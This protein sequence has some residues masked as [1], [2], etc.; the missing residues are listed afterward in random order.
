MSGDKGKVPPKKT[1]PKKTPVV[2]APPVKT[3]VAKAAAAKA[4]AAKTP[5]GHSSGKKVAAKSKDPRFAER[6]HTAY[7]RSLSSIIWLQ[8]QLNDPYV[9]RAKEE[10]W[11]SRAAFKL[12]E[13]DEKH[14][15]LK[16]GQTIIDLGCA[17][18]GWCQYAAKKVGSASGKSGQGKAGIVIGIDLLPVEPIVGVTLAEMDF[19]EEDA[20]DRLRAMLGVESGQR[21]VDGV[22][23]DMAANTTGHRKTDHLRI[24]G[25]TEMA[26]EFAIEMLKPGGFFITKLFQGGET[27]AMIT[28]LK[29]HFSVVKHVKPQSSRADSAEL[30]VLA[31]G[32]KG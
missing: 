20:P 19:T 21:V 30:Y 13:I 32:F 23:S 18:G 22:L 4:F 3:S 6:V 24:V 27:A 11:R 8:R 1:P 9:Q 7:K 17:P 29:Q 16:P 12:I 5:G 28:L 25:L 15:I 31:T 10:G 14:R 26:V 2:K